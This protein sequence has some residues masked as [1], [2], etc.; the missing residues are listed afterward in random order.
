MTFDESIIG[1]YIDEPSD[2]FLGDDGVV[3]S[4]GRGTVAVSVFE[5]SKVTKMKLDNVLHVPELKKNLLSVPAM[6]AKGAVVHFDNERCVVTKN[7]KDYTIGHKVGDKLYKLNNKQV[8]AM[9]LTARP[10]SKGDDKD[11]DAD[12]MVKDEEDEVQKEV[13]EN[14]DTAPSYESSNQLKDRYHEERSLLQ[15]KL[16]KSDAENKELKLQV[17]QRNEEIHRLQEKLKEELAR[18]VHLQGDTEKQLDL[19]LMHHVEAA[20][21]DDGEVSSYSRFETNYQPYSDVLVTASS[22]YQHYNGGERVAGNAIH[23]QYSPTDSNMVA[24]VMTE[25]LPRIKFEKF[26]SLLGGG[27][28]IE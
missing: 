16:K 21:K 15:L 14:D 6:T 26:R 1:N 25:A 18:L 24:D 5:D 7:D 27:T 28:V 2:V 9:L 20:D 12:E 17:K 10:I 11:N 13:E 19:E 4:I 8:Y 22:Q 3:P 23:V